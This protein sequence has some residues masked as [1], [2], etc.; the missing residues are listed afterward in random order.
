MITTDAGGYSFGKS[1]IKSTK[2]N[3]VNNFG[4]VDYKVFF[5]TNATV[6]PNNTSYTI[7]FE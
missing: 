2:I 3:M 5:I 7:K 6:L 1:V 4:E